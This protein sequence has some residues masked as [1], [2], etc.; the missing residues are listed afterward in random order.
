M[1]GNRIYFSDSI[2]KTIKGV[3]S[4]GTSLVCSFTDET[5][6]VL[7]SDG[8]SD[9]AI[10]FDAPIDAILML[11]KCNQLDLNE[12]LKI[13][14]ISDFEHKTQSVALQ[15]ISDEAHLHAVQ[16]RRSDYERLRSEF[17]EKQ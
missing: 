10:S 14:V 11:P 16:K 8:C 12:L 4:V 1:I 15:K 6:C 13:G 5:Y 9:E 17:E 7:R 2:G 3:A